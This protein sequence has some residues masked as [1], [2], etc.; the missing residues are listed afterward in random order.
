MALMPSYDQGV[1]M[2][3]IVDMGRGWIPWNSYRV[4]QIKKKTTGLG[5]DHF[6]QCQSAVLAIEKALC[7]V[8]LTSDCLQQCSLVK[9]SIADLRVREQYRL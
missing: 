8:E 6:P 4:S 9:D 5:D 2:R 3:Q 1:P 7:M